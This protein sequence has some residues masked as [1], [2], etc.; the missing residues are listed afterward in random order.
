MKI[1]E[2]DAGSRRPPLSLAAHLFLLTLAVALPLVGLAF[3][4]LN[5]AVEAQRASLRQGL[6]SHARSLSNLVSSRMDDFLIA[7]RLLSRSRYLL[8]GDYAAFDY[9][10]EQV[11]PNISALG[12]EVL[13]KDGAVVSRSK[14]LARMSELPE[15]GDLDKALSG[16]IRAGELH[17]FRINMEVDGARGPA[18]VSML[19]DVAEFQRVLE[20]QKY[21][22]AWVIGLLDRQ[23][24]FIARQPDP[25]RVGMPPSKEWQA[26]LRM[27]GE[28]VQELTTLEGVR[29]ISAYTQTPQG[30]T[31]GVAVPLEALDAPLQTSRYQFAISAVLSLAASLLIAAFVGKKLTFKASLIADAANNLALDR[32]VAT[33]TTGILEYDRLVQS[34]QQSAL[35]LSQRKAERDTAEQSQILSNRLLQAALDVAEIA[36]YEW[37]PATDVVQAGQKFREMWGVGDYPT[38]LSRQLMRSVSHDQRDIIRKE[39]LRALNPEDDGLFSAEFR[40]VK[41]GQERWLYCRSQT[42]FENGRAVRVIGAARDVTDRRYREVELEA[43]R[44]ELRTL[45]NAMPQLVWIAD[46]RGELVYFNEN[47]LLYHIEGTML[48]DW[49]SMIHPEDL[50]ET[51]QAWRKALESGTPYSC[52]HRLLL[53]D[54]TYAWHLSRALPMRDEGGAIVRWHGTATNI[55]EHKLREEHVRVL[56]AEVNHRSKNLLAVVQAIVRQTAR[57]AASVTEFSD[58]FNAR[59]KA[60]AISQELITAQNWQGV[61][62][63]DLARSQLDHYEDLFD[64]R[65]FVSGPYVMLG[66]DVAQSIGMALHELSTNAAK[67]GALSNSDGRVDLAWKIEA[68]DADFIFVLNWRE[69]GGPEA[70]KPEHAGFGSFVIDRMLA[71]RLSAEIDLAYAPSGLSWELVAPLH[72]IIA[73]G[74][75][76]RN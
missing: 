41:D 71:D 2:G 59:V 39:I 12:V 5:Q 8:E 23:L 67:Y 13:S 51:S 17:V 65:I 22:K 63:Y 62:M 75:A 7:T 21:D 40:V 25:S 56:L 20:R 30:W 74:G 46:G 52:E 32:V 55:H 69:K 73:G 4:A 70:I 44:Q 57:S 36:V 49:A 60:L 15:P 45:A 9:M 38:I 19:V 18:R 33:R 61:T 14:G 24:N 26:A 34:L 10:V 35:L 6:I 11:L 37:D 72:N 28:G 54:G 68:R 76:K 43:Q 27:S 53:A 48:L 47:R 58:K 3:F 50:E 42:E 64:K 31:V 29:T 1:A 66:P 16:V